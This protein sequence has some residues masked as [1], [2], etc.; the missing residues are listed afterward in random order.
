MARGDSEPGPAD[1]W[2]RARAPE[3]SASL[4][5][6]S[7]QEVRDARTRGTKDANARDCMR[8]RARGGERCASREEEA[9][10]WDVGGPRD[11][12]P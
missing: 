11:A 7:F 1:D 10:R 2:T 6:A 8:A 9:R 3:S 4:R 5:R 12:K